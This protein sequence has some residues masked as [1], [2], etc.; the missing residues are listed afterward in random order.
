VLLPI[1][2]VAFAAGHLVMSSVDDAVPDAIQAFVASRPGDYRVVNV[3]LPNNGFLLGVPDA[4]GNDPAVLRRY[5]EFVTASEGGDPGQATQHL[6]FSKLGPALAMLRVRFAFVAQ[7]DGI[8]TFENRTPPLPPALLVSTYRVAPTR[9]DVLAEVLRDGFDPRHTVWLEQTPSPEPVSA[10]P[11]G[12]V[13]VLSQTA[14][15]LEI[16]ALTPTPTILVVTDP[17]S[18]DWRARPLTPGPQAGY[19]VLVANYVL[20]AIPLA[21]GHHRL[22][23]EYRPAMLATG[24]LVS[25]LALAVLLVLWL[26]GRRRAVSA[27]VGDPPRAPTPR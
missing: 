17:Y 24:A 6:P 16:E 18:R 22:L 1:E 14:D 12:T 26:V 27:P 15:T 19:E 4:G 7:K 5:A 9:A 3:P 13:R 10:G 2:M 21:A 11:P 25:L 20:R 8:H 23:L